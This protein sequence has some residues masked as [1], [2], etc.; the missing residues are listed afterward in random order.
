MAKKG[1]LFLL[2]KS[3]NKSEKRYFKRFCFNQK[4]NNNYLRLFDAYDAQSDFD[5]LAIRQKF[6]GEPFI[7]QLH[8]TKSYLN[9]LILKSLRNYY[10]SLSRQGELK[11]LIRN[12]EIL[13][14][15]ELFD[16]C[17]YEIQ[18]AERMAGQYEQFKD[19]LAVFGWK[20]KLLLARKGLQEQELSALIGEEKVILQKTLPDQ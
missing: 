11:D 4:T 13:F 1:N 3:L 10:Q 19:L 2:I 7:R 5:D 16:Q 15:K 17:D 9:Q 12:I 8:V 18:K 14:Y 6:E 20:R